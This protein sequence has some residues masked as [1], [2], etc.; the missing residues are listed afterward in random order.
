MQQT[1]CQAEQLAQAGRKNHTEFWWVNQLYKSISVT[2][3]TKAW[4]LRP[5]AYWD[6]E[7]EYSR[8]H[9]YLSFLNAVFSGTV[10]CVGL[11]S[12]NCGV[13]SNCDR[14]ASSWKTM[15]RNEIESPRQ[16]GGGSSCTKATWSQ[17]ERKQELACMGFANLNCWDDIGSG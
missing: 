16:R 4:G 15:A 12:T 6:C 17:S 8:K 3:R 10:L 11:S 5:P 1:E 13:S 2:A 9:G 14:E 7:F